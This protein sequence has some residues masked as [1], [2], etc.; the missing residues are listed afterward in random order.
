MEEFREEKKKK[1]KFEI[2]S[3]S[4]LKMEF[5]LSRVLLISLVS[6]QQYGIIHDKE[7]FVKLH[8]KSNFKKALNIPLV[9]QVKFAYAD[10]HM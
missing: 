7:P 5:S 8:T 10:V 3:I 9:Q 2:N 6:A 1:I 4:R